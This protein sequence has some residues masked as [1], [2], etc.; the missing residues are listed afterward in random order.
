MYA[1]LRAFGTLEAFKLRRNIALEGKFLSDG[2]EHL[3][4]VLF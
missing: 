1:L 2:V 4:I 3:E